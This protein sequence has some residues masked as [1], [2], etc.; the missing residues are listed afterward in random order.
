MDQSEALPPQPPPPI[1]LTGDSIEEPPLLLRLIES[2]PDLANQILRI[3]DARSLARVLCTSMR[4]RQQA[5]LWLHLLRAFWPSSFSLNEQALSAA[6]SEGEVCDRLRAIY[7][8]RAEVIQRSAC[9]HPKGASCGPSGPCVL[10]PGA[11]HC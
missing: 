1:V 11:P 4:A 2:H 8:S 9:A 10:A 6:Q 5:L 3:C 7:V